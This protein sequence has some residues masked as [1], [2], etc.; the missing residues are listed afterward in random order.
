MKSLIK[1]LLILN[2]KAVLFAKEISR[3]QFQ[4]I[5]KSV[6]VDYVENLN[7]TLRINN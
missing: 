6:G 1:N 5:G 7:D 3:N 4:I 2:L